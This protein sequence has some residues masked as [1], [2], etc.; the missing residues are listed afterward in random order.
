MAD[1]YFAANTDDDVILVSPG[2][3]YDDRVLGE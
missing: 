1:R 2:D 3:N